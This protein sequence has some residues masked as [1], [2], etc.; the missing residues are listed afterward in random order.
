MQAMIPM[1]RRLNKFFSKDQIQS[2]LNYI[3]P[4][5]AVAHYNTDTVHFITH[6]VAS[7][8]INIEEAESIAHPVDT[9]D[10]CALAMLTSLTKDLT[11]RWTYLEV[12]DVLEKGP[13]QYQYVLPLMKQIH[14]AYPPKNPL[15]VLFAM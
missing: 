3:Q 2:M 13:T 14:K 9:V 11:R 10:G 8:F 4:T 1:C 15:L 7:F 5:V 12:Q 6:F